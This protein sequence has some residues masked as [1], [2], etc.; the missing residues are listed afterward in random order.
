MEAGFL[1]DR[2]EVEG[3][4]E[5]EKVRGGRRRESGRKRGFCHN[6]VYSR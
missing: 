6:H 4:R 1:G 2:G 5:E 3:G